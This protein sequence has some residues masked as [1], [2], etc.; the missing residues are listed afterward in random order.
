MRKYGFKKSEVLETDKKYKSI[1]RMR[2]QESLPTSV[3]LR[4]WCPPVYD[5]GQLGSCTAN[6]GCC[7]L[8][9]DEKV[10]Q[11]RDELKLASR[12]FL[13]FC[14]REIDGDVYNDGGSTLRT[15]IQ[16]LDSIG[17]CSEDSWPYNPDRFTTKPSSNCYEEA[18]NH[19]GVHSFSLSQNEYELKHCLAI[20]K[21]PF[22]FGFQVYDSFEGDQIAQT[23]IM[24]MPK[25]GEQ[26]LGG[27]AVIC[28]GYREDGYFIVRNSWGTGWGDNGYFYMPKEFMLN[29]SYCSDFWCLQ[30]VE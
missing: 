26:C 28:V 25:H 10:Q 4:E 27:H 6:A 16:A 11:E 14:E 19:R 21:R 8:Q 23:G 29:P 17:V 7:A 12:L 1:V 2:S 18:K 13:Y 9:Y 15:C 24:S 30:T 22:V 20:H 5:Q 3:D